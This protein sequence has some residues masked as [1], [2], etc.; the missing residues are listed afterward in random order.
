MKNLETSEIVGLDVP[1]EEE[2]REIGKKYKE[3]V[4][5]VPKKFLATMENMRWFIIQYFG[6]DTM[7][8]LIN[9]ANEG[10]GKKLIDMLSNIW[11]ELPDNLFN[12][13]ENPPGW[14][15]LLAI[16]EF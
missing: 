10:N 14:E 16:I 6:N 5:Q 13:V 15:D 1:S 12:I 2:M 4:D 8:S 9:L 11:F 3:F 7:N